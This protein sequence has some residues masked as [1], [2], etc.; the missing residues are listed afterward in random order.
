VPGVA[1][2]P[3]VNFRKLHAGDIRSWPISGSSS[4]EH[5]PPTETLAESTTGEFHRSAGTEAG[6][7]LSMPSP[8]LP[9]KLSYTGMLPD[10]S[11][12]AAFE[13]GS[14][15]VSRPLRRQER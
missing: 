10:R 9:T 4:T 2:L 14:T 15:V 12:G 8:W 7:D 11:L 1:I 5:T 3:D 13:L 6:C